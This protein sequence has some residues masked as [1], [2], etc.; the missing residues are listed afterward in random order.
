[1]GTV[2]LSRNI[3]VVALQS[4]NGF[5]LF[6]KIPDRSGDLPRHAFIASTKCRTT[7][8]KD[9]KK[10][11]FGD[12]P[13]RDLNSL[14]NTLEDLLFVVANPIDRGMMILIYKKILLYIPHENWYTEE[15]HW[16]VFRYG[17]LFRASIVSQPPDSTQ[18]R[19]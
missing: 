17:Q 19:L 13:N 11:R 6:T 2:Y 7:F 18:H 8:R 16:L 15:E 12:R 10:S 1:M 5:R 4:R 9:Y 3:A 14:S